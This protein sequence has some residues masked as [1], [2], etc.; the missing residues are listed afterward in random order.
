MSKLH[1]IVVHLFPNHPNG[2]MNRAWFQFSIDPRSCEVTDEQLETIK[3]DKYLKIVEP[4]KRA[5]ELGLENPAPRLGEEVSDVR[6]NVSDNW[7]TSETKKSDSEKKGGAKVL[8]AV[9]PVK[10]PEGKKIEKYNKAE[11]VF[12]LQE[13]GLTAGVDFQL[14]A[15]NKLL[16]DLLTVSQG[17]PKE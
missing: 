1:T 13:C 16:L 17:K 3:A 6:N 11:L 2:R 5:Y 7:N 14:D 9:V 15:G 4:G 8:D 10:A 12:A